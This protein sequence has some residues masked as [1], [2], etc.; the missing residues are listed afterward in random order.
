M[1][2]EMRL[3]AAIRVVLRFHFGESPCAHAPRGSRTHHCISQPA[4]AQPCRT[5]QATQNS[6]ASSSDG[7][8]PFS[9]PVPPSSHVC[10]VY[11]VSLFCQIVAR[12]R[13]PPSRRRQIPPPCMVFSHGLWLQHHA[14]IMTDASR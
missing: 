4:V 12:S 6:F 7:D 8:V 5:M 10:H 9:P 14:L 11:R 3:G 2:S 13:P 1:C